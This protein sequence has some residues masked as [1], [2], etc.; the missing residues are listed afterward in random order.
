M[1]SKDFVIISPG[2]PLALERT[3]WTLT[4]F[5]SLTFLFFPEFLSLAS[6]F[7]HHSYVDVFLPHSG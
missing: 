3:G 7:L 5:V 6:C 2:K 4:I 1:P